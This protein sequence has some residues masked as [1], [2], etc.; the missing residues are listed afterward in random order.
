MRERAKKSDRRV[1][2]TR[3]AIQE[4]FERLLKERG[5]DKI[6]VSA[7]AQEA[8]INRKTFYLHYSSVEELLDSMA[9]ERA[10]ETVQK[11]EEQRIFDGDRFDI[12]AM[13]RILG[14]SYRKNILLDPEN[15]QNLPT[16]QLLKAVQK[17]MEAVIRYE[18]ESRGLPQL[19]HTEYYVS[20]LLGG[21]LSVYEAWCGSSDE[22]PFEEAARI[23]SKMAASGLEGLV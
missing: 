23:A 2:R 7:I 10:L 4:A 1:V 13:T 21:L 3:R 19:E 16:D 12:D 11:I 6:T 18:R 17:P 15:N 14:E 8:D 5:Y 22:V 20:F 9:Q